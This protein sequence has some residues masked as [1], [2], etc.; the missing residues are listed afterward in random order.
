MLLRDLAAAG[1]DEASRSDKESAR[2]AVRALASEGLIETGRVTDHDE[3]H[4]LVVARI[5]SPARVPGLSARDD[6]KLRSYLSQTARLSNE[7]L[8]LLGSRN[9]LVVEQIELR[10]Q[11]A[12]LDGVP[13]FEY[14]FDP[15]D[16]D[17]P[18]PPDSVTPSGAEPVIEFDLPPGADK[19]PADPVSVP[20][21]RLGLSLVE[22]FGDRVGVLSRIGELS[23]ADG[24]PPGP[25]RQRGSGV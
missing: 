8:R 13:I 24:T 25:A 21:S 3:Y 10:A 19:A 4:Y 14:R 5:R 17:L 9:R 22:S 2:R 11:V 7:G 20:A 6:S 1:G 23:L 15:R 16:P 18:Q 12:G